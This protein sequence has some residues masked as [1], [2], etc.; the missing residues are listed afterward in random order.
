[1]LLEL[2][3]EVEGAAAAY[4][5]AG[6][7]LAAA[8]LCG[9]IG[10]HR[11]AVEL[12]QRH[13]D[14]LD[15]S[16][17]ESERA[18][19]RLA[20]ARAKIRLGRPDEA[21]PLLQ[22]VERST[23]P[24]WR[25][26]EALSLMLGCFS[27]L[28]Y[29][30]A[31]E[32]VWQR[33]LP[34]LDDPPADH[35]TYLARLAVDQEET[36]DDDLDERWVAGRYRLQRLLG[37][38]STGQV[39][40]AQDVA[41]GR[42]VAVKLLAGVA[43]NRGGV[44]RFFREARIARSL[45][46]PGIV[47]IFEAD[48]ARG[49]IA[50]EYLPAGTLADRLRGGRRLGVAEMKRIVAGVARAL[51]AAH[52]RGV[53]H[54]DVKPENIFLDAA[55]RPRLGDFGAAHLLSFKQTG[56]GHLLG[57]LA[58]MAPEQLDDSP[59][60]A[61][62][63]LWA[64]AVSAYR[65]LTGRLPFPGPDVA[66]QQEAGAPPPS[67]LRPGL[68]HEVDRFFE[69]AFAVDPAA[70]F[71]DAIA[72]AAAL[73]ALPEE[74]APVEE[75]PRAEGSPRAE[76]PDTGSVRY[77]VLRAMGERVSLA[78]DA[79]LGRL[80]VLERIP[81]EADA[82]LDRIRA[83]AAAANPHLQPVLDLDPEAGL[84]VYAFLDGEPLPEAARTPRPHRAALRV[85]ADVAVALVDHPGPLR[86]QRIFVHGGRAVLALAGLESLR[87]G[88]APPRDVRPTVGR[89]LGWLSTGADPGPTEGPLEAVGE[90]PPHGAAHLAGWLEEALLPKRT[91]AS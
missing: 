53:L 28:D 73:E 89:V 70:R 43:G 17:D 16:A 42:E 54:R 21:I 37:A 58:Y 46:D 77:E 86:P 71:P 4:E 62:T 51:A 66:A 79:A 41:S 87:A 7:D 10:R 29:R 81:S 63:D 33:L 68:S 12:L 40:L 45:E 27:A 82:Y 30:A 60:S 3:G 76:A 6:N 48:A 72:F 55:G 36:G 5:A 23:A 78:R 44:D 88:A 14:G 15:A 52:R 56:T 8:R 1:M 69:R 64:L 65:A 39:Y 49:Y 75:A 47:R 74:D 24:R 35:R 9:F 59:L 57:T 38:G 2:A 22:A 13:L 25:R 90:A 61:R 50:M 11:H 85:A 32:A 80:V 18:E 20:L 34:Y 91:K 67:S 19:A 26:R 83:V 31:T 84:V